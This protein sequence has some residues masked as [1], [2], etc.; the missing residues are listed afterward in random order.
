MTRDYEHDLLH[1]WPPGVL[2]DPRY[3]G[4]EL[5]NVGIVADGDSLSSFFAECQGRTLALWFELH[6]SEPYWEVDEDSF[7]DEDNK[8]VA[9][10]GKYLA[11][12]LRNREQKRV[13]T[14]WYQLVDF[15]ADFLR[16]R[17]WVEV[18]WFGKEGELWR[19]RPCS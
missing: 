2:E 11:G 10:L 19:L 12:W 6:L 7:L 5:P 16:K 17:G 4:V 18:M 13:K 3:T 15:T 1:M 8:D 14:N 9:E